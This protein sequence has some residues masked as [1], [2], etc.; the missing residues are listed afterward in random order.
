MWARLNP[1]SLDGAA[2]ATGGIGHTGSK[3]G[4]I[5]AHKLFPGPSGSDVVIKPKGAS[6]IPPYVCM[7]V[8]VYLMYIMYDLYIICD[9]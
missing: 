8:V 1:A 7:Y 5:L 6:V 3:G 9:H 2:T 4:G